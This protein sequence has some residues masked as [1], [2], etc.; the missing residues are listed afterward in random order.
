[1][2]NRIIC[3]TAQP[4]QASGFIQGDGE[5][6]T[7]TRHI[8]LKPRGHVVRG[9]GSG[10]GEVGGIRWRPWFNSG[11]R[12][13]S[14]AAVLHSSSLPSDRIGKGS[15]SVGLSGNVGAESREARGLRSPP[16]CH[17]SYQSKQS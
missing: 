12:L 17:Q 2:P 4:S 5:A 13:L 1:M 10:G 16:G 15:L 9:W 7:S 11:E 8:S 14:W 6:V 3:L